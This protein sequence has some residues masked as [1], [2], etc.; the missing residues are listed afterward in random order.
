M[1]IFKPILLMSLLAW[2]AKSSALTFQLPTNGDNV[3]GKVQWTQ[4]LPGDDFIKVGRRYDIGYYELVEANPGVDP[5]LPHPGTLLVIPSRFVIPNV[6]HTG[7]VVS[8]AE[9]RIYYFPAGTNTVVTYPVGIGREGW[10]T[11]IGVT[12]VIKKVKNPTWVV[13]PDIMKWR[14]EKENGGVQLPK[15]VPPGPNNPLGGYAFYLG[16]PGYRIHG[17]N[18]PTGIGRRSSSGCIRMWPEDVEEL[19]SHAPT[20]S[21]VRV[22]NDPFKAGWL[23]NSLYLESH[24][25]LE[26]QQHMYQTD[27]APMR[28]DVQAMTANRPAEIN[29]STAKWISDQQNGIPQVIGYAK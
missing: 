1:K 8:L 26:E 14:L 22:I 9:L 10:N 23:N 16:F 3:V 27:S 21:Q 6:P 18:D 17:T 15:S 5:N 19:F 25:P 13:P 11:P 24:T 4:S 12:H 7:I 20:G 28:Y 29:W 2:S